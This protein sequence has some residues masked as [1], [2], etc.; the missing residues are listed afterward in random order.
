MRRFLALAA[1]AVALAAGAPAARPAV[2]TRCTV[3]RLYALTIAAARLRLTFSGC[4]LG[5][6]SYERPRARRA[7]VTDE[8]PAPGAVLPERARVFLVAS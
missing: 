3:P 7:R 4:T 6:I 8:T 2:P 1:T 5:G